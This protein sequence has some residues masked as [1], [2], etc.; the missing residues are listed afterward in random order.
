MYNTLGN[1]ITIA[2]LK[3]ESYIVGL[4][5]IHAEFFHFI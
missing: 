5:E 2:V 1:M 3:H 4:N